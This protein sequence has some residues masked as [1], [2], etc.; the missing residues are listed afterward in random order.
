MWV[1]SDY[2]EELAVACAW[3]AALIPWNVSFNDLGSTGSLLFVRFP[4]FQVRYTWGVP[5][6]RAIS[7]DSVLGALSRQST[8][9]LGEAY[10]GWAAGAGVVLVAVALGVA[11]YAELDVLDRVPTVR[12]VGALLLLAGLVFAVATYL[13]YTRGLPGVPI[14]VGVAFQVAFGVVLLR[15]ELA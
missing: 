10:L 9:T 4:F 1:R 15:A 3:L 11:M 2:A 7:L 13:L 14:P 6:A 12:S 8:T 5:L